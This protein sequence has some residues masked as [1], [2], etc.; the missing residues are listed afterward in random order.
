MTA[1]LFGVVRPD[2]FALS[3]VLLLLVAAA[4]LALAAPA[5]RASRLDP[6]EALR[7]D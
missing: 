7:R 6:V 4:L 5:W 3:G 2:P 1:T